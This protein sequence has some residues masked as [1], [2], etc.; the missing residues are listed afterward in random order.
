[1]GRDGR[2]YRGDFVSEK[3]KYF[4][5]GDWT[6]QIR[7]IWLKKLNFWRNGFCAAMNGRRRPRRLQHR[8]R[9]RD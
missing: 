7:L 5:N 6:G 4:L 1:V 8:R 3:Q 9:R 2:E